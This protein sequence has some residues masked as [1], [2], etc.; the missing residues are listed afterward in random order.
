MADTEH[1]SSNAYPGFD[2]V[3]GEMLSF[4]MWGSGQTFATASHPFGAAVIHPQSDL[5]LASFAMNVID[6]QTGMVFD[7]WQTNTRIYPYYERL[8]T[9]GPARYPRFSSVFP[10]VPRS[11]DGEA[12]L[13]LVYNRSAGVVRWII[14]DREAARVDRIGFPS[15]DA[16]ML[17]DRGRRPQSA[18]PRQLKCGMGCSR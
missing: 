18:A 10:G 16:I 14:N 6:Y 1:T 13:S 3:P 4:T 9:S 8:E 17:I 12:K 11:P 7:T 5:R 15:A 2:A